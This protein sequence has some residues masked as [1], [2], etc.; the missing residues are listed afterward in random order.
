MNPV[1]DFLA[2][3]ERSLRGRLTPEKVAATLVEARQRMTRRAE[4]LAAGG[5]AA[6]AAIAAASAAFGTPRQWASDVL[7]AAG[8][9]A[10]V[11]SA[12]YV[13][14][15]SFVLCLI[16]IPM[17]VWLLSNMLNAGK[18]SAFDCA[19]IA[20]LLATPLAAF[21]APLGALI[22]GRCEV[23]TLAV[24]A[25]VLALLSA[26]VT[27]LSIPPLMNGLMTQAAFIDYADNR[28]E[29]ALLQLGVQTYTAANAPAILPKELR[30]ANGYL[31]PVMAFQPF[32]MRGFFNDP[33][34]TILMTRGDDKGMEQVATEDKAARRWREFGAKRLAECVRED[35]VLERAVIG[36]ASVTPSGFSFAVAWKAGLFVLAQGVIGLGLCVFFAWIG[37]SAQSSR[38]VHPVAGK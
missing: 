32:T 11:K 28:E 33:I 22:A 20:G 37:G 25:A 15:A 4:D 17:A 29:Q 12:N 34:T 23:K 3:A 24:I 14:I 36:S 6:D 19:L 9:R 7:R 13:S 21:V 18:M 1:E 2:Q 31:A 38:R 35:G 27:G 26:I 30:G 16:V 8:Y 5:L 10:H